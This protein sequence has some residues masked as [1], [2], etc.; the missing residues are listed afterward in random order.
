MRTVINGS[1][2]DV[3]ETVKA[4]LAAG[5]QFTLANLYMIGDYDDP[6]ALRITSWQSALSWPI[7]GTFLPAV[8]KRGPVKSAI[9]LSVADLE[10]TWTPPVSP[11]SPSIASASPYQLAQLGFFDNKFA[12]CWVTIMPTPG[13]ADT[14][15]AYILFGGRVGKCVTDRGK[16]IFTVNSFLD[17]VDEMVPTNVIEMTNTLAA[18]KGAT[19]PPGV[20]SIPQFNVIVGSTTS[21]IIADET[22]PTAHHI[23]ADQSLAGAFLVFNGGL[24]STLARVLGRISTNGSVVI[25]GTTYNTFFLYDPL[26]WVPTPGVDSFY[27]SAP[28]PINSQDGSYQGFKYVPAPQNGV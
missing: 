26:P 11:F 20:A 27:V 5:Y 28:F 3:T 2:I 9:G 15:G 1:G 14:Y 4:Y 22:S 8:V 19:P 6:Q 21:K 24:G 18:Y 17:V 23:Y 10:I 13:D 12:R 7:Q 25:S 16:I